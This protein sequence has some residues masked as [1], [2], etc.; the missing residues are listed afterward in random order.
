MYANDLLMMAIRTVLQGD[1]SSQESDQSR[2]RQEVEKTSQ[3]ADFMI[4][5]RSNEDFHEVAATEIGREDPAEAGFS[6]CGQR[7][8]SKGV[9]NKVFSSTR[10]CRN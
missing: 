4:Q 3:E 6:W 1:F 9:K 10:R 5:M 8:E 7:L 2:E